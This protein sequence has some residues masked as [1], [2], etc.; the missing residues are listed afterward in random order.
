VQ[1]STKRLFPRWQ[2][3]HLAWIPLFAYNFTINGQFQYF[4]ACR[5]VLIIRTK[6]LL[7]FFK[8]FKNVDARQISALWPFMDVPP[9]QINL[10]AQEALK[11]ACQFLAFIDSEIS[12]FIRRDRRTWLDLLG[13]MGSET[14]RSTC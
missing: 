14:L 3:H 7:L 5:W 8:I 2:P 4:L 11:S 1:G 6:P 9:A 10:A 12:A 13:F